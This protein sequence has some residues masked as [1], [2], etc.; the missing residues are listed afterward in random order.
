M[1]LRLVKWTVFGLLFTLIGL[2]TWTVLTPIRPVSS[3]TAADVIVVFGAGMDTDGTLHPSSILRVER[4]VALYD[5]GLAPRL[6]FTGGR[7]V[8]TGPSAGDQMA[9][10][11]I[12]SGVPDAAI[13]RETES[14]S[15][16][17]NTLFSAPDLV[18]I[19]SAILVSEG[20]HLPRVAASFLWA[21]GPTD[22]QLAVSTKFR[23]SPPRPVL[24]S[25]KMMAREALAWWFNGARA[26]AFSIGG[27]AGVDN[28]TRRAWLA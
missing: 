6:H 27:A 14:L 7:G 16:L 1:I 11:A 18:D 3:F 17:Q 25:A 10:L 19:Q 2:T 20:F 23:A 8:A 9:A 26:L 15:T 22:F 21:G 13:T 24:S 12:A 5:A 4:G 28:D